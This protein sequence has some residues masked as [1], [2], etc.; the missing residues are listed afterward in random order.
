MRVL[1]IDPA[2][3]N[4]GFAVL[5]EIKGT[6]RFLAC[7]VIRNHKSKKPS[8]CL[9]TIHQG[10][11]EIITTHQPDACAVEGVIFVQSHATAILMGAARGAALVAAA[12]NGLPIFE[13][14]P[15]KV[16]QVV[17]GRGAANK[18]QVAFMVRA[19]LK[20]TETPPSDAADAL[21]VAYTHLQSLRLP[22]ALS[23]AREI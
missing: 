21:A 9:V 13:Y 11:N 6:I 8:E 22:P 15:R 17:V 12:T 2:L 5:E 20:L 1:G 14:A 7:G 16:K 3:R 19:L 4:A 18:D 23:D 10:I